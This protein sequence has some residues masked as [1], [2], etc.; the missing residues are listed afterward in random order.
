MPKD[1]GILLSDALPPSA[2]IASALTIA[3]SLTATGRHVA[4]YHGKDT[5]PDLV[6]HDN[7]RRWTRGLIVVGSFDGIID[8]LDSPMT[9]LVSNAG[10][11]DM[12]NSLAAARIG[13][14]PVLLVSDSGSSRIA[15]LFGNPS[16]TALR[17][18][19]FAS[20]GTISMPPRPSDRVSLNDLGLTP[21]RADVFGRAELAV[22]V[23]SRSLPS[24]TR[25]S[26]LVL[27]VMV[28]PDGAGEKA[29]V[30]AFVNERLLA[31]T[32]AAI[33]DPTRLD[34]ALP[35][36]LVGRL[37]T[38]EWL[39][40]A[41]VHKAIA[42]LKRKVTRPRSSAPARSFCRK[43][44]RPRGT[45]PTSQRCGATASRFCC[46]RQRRNTRFPS[47]PRCPTC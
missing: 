2:D 18:T 39:C 3:R 14:V 38:S 8:R 20:V 34:F 10:G 7:R 16:L 21:P 42:G 22:T 1:V 45:S 15:R 29:V 36:R 25:P 4:F 46:R 32:V 31:S 11:A 43:R 13:G 28:A 24:G 40:S 17:D 5:I 41:A 23:A 19:S 27:D 6:E 9:T 37:P 44:D 33:G 47:W 26:R 12:A 30:S 35:E